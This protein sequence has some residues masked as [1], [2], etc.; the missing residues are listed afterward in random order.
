MKAF[1]I[2]YYSIITKLFELMAAIT[3]LICYRKF[4]N[5]NV[6]YF[7]FFL[8]YILFVENI[9][10]YPVYVEN[11]ESFKWL[12]I[13]FED[14]VFEENY[15]WFQ[16]FWT[17]ASTLFFLF[18]FRK[19]L[20]NFYVKQVVKYGMYS[21]IIVSTLIISLQWE[22]LKNTYFQS[23]DVISFFIILF[24]VSAY[25]IQILKSEKVLLFYHHFPFYVACGILVFSILTTPL[26]F[27]EGYFNTSDWNYI[28]LKWQV[29]LFAN[30]FMYSVFSIGL[31]VC[32]P[33][34]NSSL[35]N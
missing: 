16:I 7:I 35:E 5:T 31:I 22:I 27:F 28:I 12:S 30:I 6:K 15:W 14:T 2:E 26:T 8:I 21:Y 13:Y 23:I 33:E 34:K 10:N 24:I 9:G 32:K 11:N 18:F 17:V 29:F 20:N 4:K 3:G 25:F 19:N 1:L